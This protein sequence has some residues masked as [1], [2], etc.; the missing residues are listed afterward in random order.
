[1]SQ[2]AV[3]ECWPTMTLEQWNN[4]LTVRFHRG[5]CSML[6]KKATIEERKEAVCEAAKAWAH[7]DDIQARLVGPDTDPLSEA[8]V[9]LYNAVSWVFHDESVER[10]RRRTVDALIK[11]E[12][13]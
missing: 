1:M 3:C 6:Q 7:S 2:Y 5:F 13:E 4:P 12:G 8:E 11:A 10:V 9:N